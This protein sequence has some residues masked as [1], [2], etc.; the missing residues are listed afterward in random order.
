MTKGNTVLTVED[1][2]KIELL[3]KNGLKDK[4]IAEVTGKSKNTINRI[5]NGK[6][7]LQLA[8]KP[9]EKPQKKENEKIKP[10]APITSELLTVEN[11]VE[12]KLDEIINLLREL[13]ELWK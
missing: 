9:Q 10:I 13:L 12:R 7:F 2:T 6:H 1:V 4:T 5:R 11:D 3:I 8:D